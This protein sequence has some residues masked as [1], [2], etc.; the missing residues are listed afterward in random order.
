LAVLA[1][2]A[3]VLQCGAWRTYNV[4]GDHAKCPSTEGF[5]DKQDEPQRTYAKEDADK[6]IAAMTKDGQATLR[7]NHL[8]GY[9][10]TPGTI[11]DKQMF[12]VRAKDTTA[13]KK[14]DSV[15][16]AMKAFAEKTGLRVHDFTITLQDK[17]QELKPTRNGVIQDNG[18][19]SQQFWPPSYMSLSDAFPSDSIEAANLAKTVIPGEYDPQVVIAVVH[20]MCHF[21][22]FK[23]DPIKFA[24][25]NDCRP[26]ADSLVSGY[27]SSN[28]A[29]WVAE[30]CTAKYFGW[31]MDSVEA[32]KT[33]LKADVNQLYTQFGGFDVTKK[34]SAEQ[35]P[36]DKNQQSLQPL[37][38]NQKPQTTKT[39]TGNK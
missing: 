2:A 5:T 35:K 38:S 7:S 28:I 10:T 30:V 29:E 15:I 8:Q 13:K 27:A 4:F 17:A 25:A 1:A 6:R 34:I 16:Y 14:I 21:A 39:T 9:I 3:M 31:A 19:V 24:A 11:D 18:K 23:N 32:F 26:N 20:E 36:N 12:R 22:H 33:T 37:Q